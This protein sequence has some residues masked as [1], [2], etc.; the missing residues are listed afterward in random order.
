MK[1]NRFLF[2]FIL[3][4]VSIS[5][6]LTPV[7]AN[8]GERTNLFSANLN[9]ELITGTDDIT[10]EHEKRLDQII[11]IGS[12]VQGDSRIYHS[13][14]YFTVDANLLSTYSSR[15]VWDYTEFE[16]TVT[17]LYL[18]SGPGIPYSDQ[19]YYETKYN[20]FQFN[21]FKGYGFN[22]N[23]G[24]QIS[25][26]DLNPSILEI[27]GE[28]FT[29]ITS[30]FHA[31]ISEKKITSFT[32]GPIGEYDVGYEGDNEA[33]LS[34]MDLAE[35]E[36]SGEFGLAEQIKLLDLG[37]TRGDQVTTTYQQGEIYAQ[38]GVISNNRFACT[39]RP[40]VKITQESV[41]VRYQELWVD[42]STGAFGLSPAGILDQM[43]GPIVESNYNRYIG[44]QVKNYNIHL[45]FEIAVDLYSTTEIQYD[46]NSDGTLDELPTYMLE[47]VYFNN[48]FYGDVGGGI[49]FDTSDPIANWLDSIWSD[50]KWL[51][52]AVIAVVIII[53]IG[54]VVVPLLPA[55]L[56]LLQVGAS[57]GGNNVRK[58][59]R[60]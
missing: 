19:T 7:L 51:I 21:K 58:T 23:I 10:V 9:F 55:L 49:V 20:D 43:S 47:D 29:Q 13:R 27:R 1:S 57:T 52:I 38:K 18:R 42:T 44:W 40:D 17:W 11:A 2:F 33:S 60:R 54:S 24:T 59:R 32:Y 37:V 31:E 45:T 48:L 30:D 50:Y 22:G 35:S 16:Q 28:Q 26:T 25:F 39:L 34:G 3:L 53:L 4:F 14:L 36:P 5:M 8:E 46:Y 15:D 12:T 41:N 56:P 6:S